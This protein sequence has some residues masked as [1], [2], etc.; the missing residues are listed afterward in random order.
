MRL[1]RRVGIA[2]RA[3]SCR[4][5]RLVNSNVQPAPK[6]RAAGTAETSSA[7]FGPG[8]LIGTSGPDRGPEGRLPKIKY[9]WRPPTSIRADGAATPGAVGK[10]RDEDRKVAEGGTTGAGGGWY[11]R[12]YSSAKTSRYLGHPGT[13]DTRKCPETADVPHVPP[14]AP[15]SYTFPKKRTTT[16]V[17]A[18][19]LPFSPRFPLCVRH[20]G[21]MGRGG[22]EGPSSGALDRPILPPRV[23]A[24]W[25]STAAARPRVRRTG[26]PGNP[27]CGAKP[28]WSCGAPVPS[29]RPWTA[30]HEP[31]AA[32][33]PIQ[34]SAWRRLDS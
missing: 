26:S 4:T 13:W 7:G 32:L 17:S 25:D 21:H 27:G 18:S 22:R 6:G 31:F 16:G 34:A 3:C 23:R 10:A 20:M 19:L 33:S 12:Q 29:S 24:M 11:G 5:P 15:I 9:G 1:L 8:S 28:R 14:V 30:R 2:R